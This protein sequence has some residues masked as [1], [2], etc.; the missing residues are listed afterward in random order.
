MGRLRLRRPRGPAESVSAGV[1]ALAVLVLAVRMGAAAVGALSAAWPVL[2]V[3]V[4]LVGAV[5]AWR[6]GQAVVV[7]RRD[8]E[9]LAT[10]RITLAEFDAMDDRAFEYALRD[11]LVR[12]GWPARRV[13]GG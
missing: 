11:L 8:R 3:F 10:A 7:G 4:L 9:R 13:G 5:L 6:I 12:D 1:V 2:L